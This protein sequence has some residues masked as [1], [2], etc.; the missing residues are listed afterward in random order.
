MVE[1]ELLQLAHLPGQRLARF[2]SKTTRYVVIN[3]A[4][5]LHMRIDYRA[6][7]ELEATLFK[8]LRQC[9]RLR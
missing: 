2:V 1:S 6:A 4:G 9:V 5:R 3:H 8:V 7:D